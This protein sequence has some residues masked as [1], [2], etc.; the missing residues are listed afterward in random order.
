MY[1]FI[2]IM[3][4]ILKDTL[5]NIQL[6]HKKLKNENSTVLP[7]SFG[8]YLQEPKVTASCIHTKNMNRH[9]KLKSRD[10]IM[11]NTL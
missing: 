1:N 7:Q 9:L 10:G 11:Y 8:Q 5:N 4:K 2:A 3:Y 6:Y